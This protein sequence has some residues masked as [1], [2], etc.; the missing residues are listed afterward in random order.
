MNHD[1]RARGR[2][3]KGDN[4]YIHSF[5]GKN[6]WLPGTITNKQGPLTYRITLDDDRVVQCHKD[7]IRS[8]ECSDLATCRDS[9][10]F[11]MM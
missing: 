5:D 4:V 6:K 1:A 9:N 11:L 10:F 7:H 8:R 3:L 2:V